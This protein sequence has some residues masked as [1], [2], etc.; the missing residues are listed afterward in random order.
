MVTDTWSLRMGILRSSD[1]F[2]DDEV[3]IRNSSFELKR[4]YA[5]R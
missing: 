5:Y 3:T 4:I 2:G 1:D